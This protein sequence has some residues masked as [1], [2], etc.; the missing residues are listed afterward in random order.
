MT[1]NGNFPAKFNETDSN[2][3]QNNVP[4]SLTVLN[5]VKARRTYYSYQALC[6]HEKEACKLYILSK[7]VGMSSV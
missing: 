1:E 7:S 4:S 5:Y 2:E 3:L 6:L